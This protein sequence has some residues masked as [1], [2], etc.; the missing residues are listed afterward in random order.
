MPF[1]LVLAVAFAGCTGPQ[2][3]GDAGCASAEVPVVGTTLSPRDFSTHFASFFEEAAR[4]GDV[5]GWGGLI[6]AFADPGSAPY[7]MAGQCEAH[8][9][10][11][12]LQTAPMAQHEAGFAVEFDADARQT[13]T[14]NL[15]AFVEAH[16]VAYL[17]L[18]VE[19]NFWKEKASTED[20]DAFVAW[21]AGAYDAVKGASP[22][23]R[24]FPTFQYERMIG[25][26]GGLWGGQD[27]RPTQWEVLDEF[28][29]RDLTAFTTYP[30]LVRHDPS[31]IEDDYWTPIRDHVSGPLA[32]TEMGWPSQDVADGWESDPDEQAA[33]VDVFFDHVPP[34]DLVVWPWLYDQDAGQAF[35]GLGLRADD[36]SPRPAWDRWVDRT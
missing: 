35:V 28:P 12:F 26:H 23:T 16:D 4:M 33:Y 10:Q 20:W 25:E 1:V 30:H 7:L 15:V 9:F 19:V 31:D 11:L 22:A 17:G 14:D 29:D 6:D 8:G 13:H 3:P 36:G 5:N 32:F 24:V 21:Y 2:P 34:A 18:G 27:G